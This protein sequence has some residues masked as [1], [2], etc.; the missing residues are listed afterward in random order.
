MSDGPWVFCGAARLSVPRADAFEPPARLPRA[1]DVGDS[2]QRA[3]AGPVEAP[4]LRELARGAATVAVAI[5]DASR[6]CPS[7][8]ILEHLLEE[9]RGAGVP[10]DGITVVVG[11]G[12]HRTTSAT[13]REGLAGTAPGRRV[14]TEDAQG[15]ETPCADLGL[16]SSG[17]P[18]HIARRVAE[19]DLAVTVGVVE[20][21]LYAG[22][23][24]GVKGVAIGCA[25]HQTIAWT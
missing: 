7:P 9:L 12:L 16:T 24:G 21:H 14:R 19:A 3:L 18:V 10:D 2:V 17:A 6:P 11:C 15:L 5:P 22:F 1:A 20:P 13:E 8:A 25:G 23:S 4:R